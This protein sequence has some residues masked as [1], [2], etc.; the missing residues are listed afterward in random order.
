MA[1]APKE[2]LADGMKHLAAAVDAMTNLSPDDGRAS[3]AGVASLREKVI[4][5]HKEARSLWGS[6]I[7][8]TRPREILR[9]REIER[10]AREVA[11]FVWK[12]TNV[13]PLTKSP[14]REA[15]LWRELR[16]AL[17]TDT[18]T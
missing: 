3:T 5:L 12:S 16:A 14:H 6:M 10:A 17:D 2:L 13:G 18:T 9:L 1:K 4:A 8:G 7:D 11:D 15:R